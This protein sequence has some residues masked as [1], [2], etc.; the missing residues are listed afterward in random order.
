MNAR[1]TASDRASVE[2]VTAVRR[3]TDALFSFRTTRAAGFAFTPGQFARLGLQ[4]GDEVL[5]R[6]YSIVSAPDAPE[7][8]YYAVLVPD[9]AFS[10]HLHRLQPGDSILT[11]RMNHGFMTV[12]R[13]GA[14]A[15]DLWMLA[16]G[17]GIGPFLS[18]L[19][20]PQIWRD[21]RNLILVHGVR[22]AEEL[23]YRDLLRQLQQSPPLA[24]AAQLRLLHSTT[25]E[26]ASPGGLYGRITTL[27][28]DGRLE[29]AAGLAIDSAQSHV[30]IC[31]NPEMITETR[32]LLHARGLR[33]C[34]RAN[35]GHYLS[36]NYW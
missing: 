17:T 31:G 29:Q 20:D 5:W 35:P 36:E 22:R 32:Q 9:G 13:F 24:D 28:Q 21:Y 12:D 27:L 1:T 30:L 16:T 7:L 26:P 2:T 15:R 14:P 23:A 4:I 10:P 25:R 34:R 6:A 11:E 8:E 19:Q 18:M 3:W 33:P